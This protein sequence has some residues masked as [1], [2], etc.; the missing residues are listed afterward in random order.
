[1]THNQ[2]SPAQPLRR[3]SSMAASELGVVRA[4]GLAAAAIYICTLGAA[5]TSCSRLVQVQLAL[6]SRSSK[7]AIAAA[8]ACFTRSHI[9]P[10]FRP[11]SHWCSA[12]ATVPSSHAARA[13]S[14]SQLVADTAKRAR[15]ARA[16]SLGRWGG[17]LMLE[18]TAPSL[19]L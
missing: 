17:T 14:S 6:A 3:L 8:S 5:T 4:C 18:F 1:M 2:R 12:A 13:T 11:A 19:S 15:R 16:V 7:G 9:E 10:S